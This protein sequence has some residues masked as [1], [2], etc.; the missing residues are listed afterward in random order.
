MNR[1]TEKHP[2]LR[3]IE[4]CPYKSD[5]ADKLNRR[6]DY[7]ENLKLSRTYDQLNDSWTISL[8]VPN[9]IIGRDN[10]SKILA[11]GDKLKEFFSEVFK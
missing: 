3:T 5:A 11:I 9:S 6:I 2:I 10:R 1:D 7:L 8:Q 4:P